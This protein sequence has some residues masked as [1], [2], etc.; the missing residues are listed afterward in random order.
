M[1]TIKHESPYGVYELSLKFGKYKNGQTSINLF[2]MADGMPY[3]KA[4]ICLDDGLLKENE[5]A[6]KNYSENT[7]ILET[8]I[9]N[10][11]VEEPHEYIQSGF[12]NIPICKLLISI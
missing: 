11:I 1:R 10:R 12:V 7:G 8:L 6:I 3:A 2:D 9:Q 4:T 5:V